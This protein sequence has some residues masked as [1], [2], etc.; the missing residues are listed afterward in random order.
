MYSQQKKVKIVAQRFVKLALKA[1]LL[2]RAFAVTS[3]VSFIVW[4]K[5]CGCCVVRMCFIFFL[6]NAA[7]MA[8]IIGLFSYTVNFCESMEDVFKFEF[9]IGIF[10]N[11]INDRINEFKIYTFGFFKLKF[12]FC[13]SNYVCMY[14]HLYAEGSV[15]IWIC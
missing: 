13:G 8:N 3:D 15:N 5:C 9:I 10:N 1:L 14:G 6:V 12:K 7:N 11:G 2:Y 4:S